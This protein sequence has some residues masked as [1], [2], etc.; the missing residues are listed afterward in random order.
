MCLD[1]C[2]IGSSNAMRGLGRKDKLE[3][4]LERKDGA[5]SSNREV[6]NSFTS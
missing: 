5:K 1:N 4:P 2:L 6:N 3:M